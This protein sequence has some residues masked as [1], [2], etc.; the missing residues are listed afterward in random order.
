M[1]GLSLIQGS[2][3]WLAARVGKATAS[4]MS[5]L[6]AKTKTGWGAARGRYMIDLIGERL[7]G[8]PTPSYTTQAMQWGIEQ[9]PAARAAYEFLTDATVDPAGFVDHPTIPMS[10]ASPDGL[11]DKD[12]LVEIKCPGT[13][14]HID[15][16]LRRAV[17]A[18]Y[19]PQITWQLACTGRA[20]CDFI[21]F[22]PRLPENLRLC[23]I[24]VERDAK[25]I[26]DLEAAVVVFLGEL[27]AMVANL[28]A[29]TNPLPELALVEG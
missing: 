29:I 19:L 22:D 18:D 5:D 23:V 25:A 17:P 26:S 10:G 7:T 9:E 16:L 1:T 3:E 27:D 14:A 13:A 15:T 21:S 4:R 8:I 28:N 20:W 6:T 11:A 24:R 2:R 12:G